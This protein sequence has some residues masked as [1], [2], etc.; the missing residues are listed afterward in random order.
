MILVEA[1]QQDERSFDSKLLL[2]AALS[3]RGH[4]AV[5]DDATLPEGWRRQRKYDAAPFLATL[6][7]RPLS[8]MLLI[9]AEA[10]A[11][12]TLA[13]LR[14]LDLPETAP[15]AAMGTFDDHQAAV[16]AQTRVAYALGREPRLVDLSDTMGGPVL[17]VSPLI[18]PMPAP[19]PRDR[20][21]RPPRL[22]LFLPADWIDEP[23]I[24]PLLAALDNAPQFSLSIVMPGVGKDR[25][26]QTRYA[27][28]DVIGYSDI[29][30]AALA[31]QTDIAAFF[32]EGSPGERMATLA[33]EL[34]AAGKV[35]IDCTGGAA[36]ETWGAP[37]L[38]GPEE[39]SALFP[40]LEATVLPNRAALGRA[41]GTSP[42]I[43]ARGID[44][45]EAAAG[46]PTPPKAPPADTP[47]RI[48]FLPTNGSGLGHAQR[49]A[50]IAESLARPNEALFLAFP[51]C[52]PLLRSHGFPCLPLVQKSPDHA[53][54]YAN[55]LVNYLRLRRTLTPRDHL[56]FDGGYVFDSIFRTIVETG[57]RAT[58]IRR[59]LWRPGQVTH[60]ALD[61]E[62]VFDR[63]LVPEEA[64]PELNVDY[65]RGP[66]IERVGPVVQPPPKAEPDRET[67]RA[68][69]AETFGI[70][71]DTLVVTMLG[72]GVAVDRSAQLHA[73][74]GFLEPRPRCLHLAVVWPHARVAPGLGGWRNTRL[75]RT[76]HS[77]ALMRAADAVVSAVGYN[78]FH[79]VLYNRL[80]AIFIPQVASYLDDQ[81]RRA[82]A[83]S[84]RD[85]AATVLAHELLLLDRRLSDLLDHGGAAALR[86]RLAAL[87]L[88]PTG[89]AQAA[90]LI[91]EV[92]AP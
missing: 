50:Q 52:V 40:F 91:E 56:V 44:R 45:L 78:T 11:T 17:G 54:D 61:R 1:G 34:C 53:E 29:L 90:R 3:Q 23:H 48:V 31:R 28:L 67:L 38:R 13:R 21:G 57:C 83:A 27:G 19:P 32:G 60:A 65:S 15:L 63:I 59:G 74:A 79:E 87:D 70:Q 12:G 39:P 75:V 89:N 66:R 68:R 18:A 9:G 35:A 77:L 82:R 84:D 72:G 69:L 14:R 88:P 76:R 62:R 73:V 4:A 47:P 5:L 22:L 41:A 42:W 6:D 33:V 36:L 25:L 85:L 16:A 24:L 2:A 81:E 80:P 71:F 43:A 49:C 10:I 64:F 92:T 86:S 8:A 26:N 30:P 46:L 7:D 58:W 20:R 55:D 51:S 37:V